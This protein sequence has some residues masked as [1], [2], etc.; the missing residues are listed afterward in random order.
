MRIIFPLLMEIGFHPDGKSWLYPVGRDIAALHI[1]AFAIQSFIDR[2]LNHQSADM[3]NPVAMLHHQK[4]LML[5]RQRL[6]GDNDDAKISDDTINA[7]LKLASAA[8]FDGSAE[9]SKQH[10]QGLRKMIDL[11]GGISALGSNVKLLVEI[12]R[13]SP[14]NISPIS[15]YVLTKAFQM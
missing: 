2:V 1:N 12:W 8:Q 3:V 13:Y 4:G 15:H 9:I 11:R 5:L 10:M 6:D 7:I 14:H